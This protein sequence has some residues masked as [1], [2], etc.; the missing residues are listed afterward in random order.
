MAL[1]NTLTPT[2]SR[3]G[4]GSRG[5]GALGAD[6]LQQRRGGFV[7]GVLG[8]EFPGEGLLEDA[9]A[10]PPGPLEAGTDHGLGLLDDRE[11]PLDLGDDTV[12]LGEGREGTGRAATDLVLK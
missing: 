1:G 2:L 9:L 8:H 11:P 3:R 5:G 4:R 10:Q 12:L 7:V 6:A